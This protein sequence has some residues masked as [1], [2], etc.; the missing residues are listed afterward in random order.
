MSAYF[1]S[2]IITK[3]YVPEPDSDLATSLLRR[4]RPPALLTDLH[5]LELTTAWHLKV[6]RG[7]LPAGAVAKALADFEQDAQAGVWLRPEHDAGAVFARAE[8]LA[9][10]HVIETGAR[11]LDIL[12]VAAALVLEADDFV[13][14][15]LRQGKLAELAGLRV[16][17]LRAG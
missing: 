16:S 7:E 11:S 8:A 10:A 3:W 2:G 6:F 4:F 5:R 13:T 12:H 1:D 15:D 14:G 9:R 17:R